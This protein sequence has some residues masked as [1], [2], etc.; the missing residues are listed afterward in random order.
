MRKGAISPFRSPRKEIVVP[1][2][3]DRIVHQKLFEFL[4]DEKE[5][6]D[7][8]KVVETE[9]QKRNSMI[10]KQLRDFDLYE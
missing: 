4:R 3:N 8:E 1:D 10:D 6:R 9:E 2:P 7:Q 5:R